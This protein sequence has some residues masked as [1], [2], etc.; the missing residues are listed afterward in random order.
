[1]SISLFS[2][3]PFP[4]VVTIEPGQHNFSDDS[5]VAIDDGANR[6]RRAGRVVVG[7]EP[8]DVIN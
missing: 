2:T 6:L 5:D 7:R 1:M 4:S 3:R 8:G